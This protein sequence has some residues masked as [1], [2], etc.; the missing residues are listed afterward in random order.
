[1]KNTTKTA[2][3]KYGIAFAAGGGL[4][5]FCLSNNGY[6]TAATQADKYRCLC[7]AFTIPGTVLL[8]LGLLCIIAGAGALDGIAYAVRSLKRA[9]IPFA[10]VK[11]E[12]YGDYV[13][14]RRSKPRLKTG[15]LLVTGGAF[16]AAA[17]LFMVLFYQIYK[18]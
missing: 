10:G 1:M 15:F 13:K 14:E 3:I 18:K 17:I 9:F 11:H 6:Y 16:M 2:L 4:C 8:M 7:D 12:R 5:L